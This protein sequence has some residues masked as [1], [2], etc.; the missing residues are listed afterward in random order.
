[1]VKWMNKD[2]GNVKEAKLQEIY[3]FWYEMTDSGLRKDAMN[4]CRIHDS[5]QV[6]S[7]LPIP[8]HVKLCTCK[9]KSLRRMLLFALL[10]TTRTIDDGFAKKI[11]PLARPPIHYSFFNRCEP[12]SLLTTHPYPK[13]VVSNPVIFLC[14]SETA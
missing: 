12:S 6:P 5:P 4:R 3:R 10:S 11:V 13:Y 7:P 2:V 8:P 1:M 9:K 14:S